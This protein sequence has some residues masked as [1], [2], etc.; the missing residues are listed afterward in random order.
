MAEGFASKPTVV[1]G[2]ATKKA[3]YDALVDFVAGSEW[4]D[5]DAGLTFVVADFGKT[6]RVDSGGAQ[7]VNL[8]SVTAANI[9][10]RLAVVKLGAG[11]VTIQAADADTIA[12]GAGGGTLINSTASEDYAVIILELASATEWVIVG[13]MGTWATSAS[14]FS[15]GVP[16]TGES[17]HPFL[18]FGG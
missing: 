4:L 11:N 18:L 1:V 10:G 9:G 6:A 3:D 5:G 8:P 14:I 2:E 7:T 12:D 13:G 16:V 17:F 15:Y